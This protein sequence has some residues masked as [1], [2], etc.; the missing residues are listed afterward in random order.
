MNA[1]DNE[2]MDIS[3]AVLLAAGAPDAAPA[4]ADDRPASAMP[5][6]AA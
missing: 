6:P 2:K 4:P 1:L 5:H 3:L